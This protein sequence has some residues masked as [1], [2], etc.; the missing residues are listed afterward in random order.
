[1]VFNHQKPVFIENQQVSPESTGQKNNEKPGFDA[2]FLSKLKRY[3]FSQL[4]S[5]TAHI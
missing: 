1:M 3:H 2:I 4:P 5:E